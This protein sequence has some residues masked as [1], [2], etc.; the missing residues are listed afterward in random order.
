MNGTRTNWSFSD[1]ALALARAFLNS[2]YGDDGL[3]VRWLAPT[4]QFLEFGAEIFRGDA[5]PAA[6]GAARTDRER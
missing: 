3:Q 1:A 6:N 2:Q 4:D 5:Y